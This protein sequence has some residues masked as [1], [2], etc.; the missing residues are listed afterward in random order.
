VTEVNGNLTAGNLLTVESRTVADGD[1]FAKS[2]A[3]ALGGGSNTVATVNIGSS[4]ET[5]ALT[6]TDIQANADLIGNQVVI[7]AFVDNLRGRAYAETDTTAAG[8]S[9]C[10]RDQQH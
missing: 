10:H 3:G 7:G 8:G 9:R 4:G 1:A 5:S 6:R 2:D